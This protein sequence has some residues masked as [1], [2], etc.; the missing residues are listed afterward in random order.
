MPTRRSRTLRLR[1]TRRTWPNGI[2]RGLTAIKYDA[3]ELKK[4][5][6]AG[7]QPVWKSWVAESSAKGVPAQELLDMVLAEAEKAKKALGKN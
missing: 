1:P 4:F 3:A 7:A 6:Q 5:E 2:K